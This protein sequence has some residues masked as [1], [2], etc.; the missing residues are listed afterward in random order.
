MIP[1]Y[2]SY[3]SANHFCN[4]LWQSDFHLSVES[5]LHGLCFEIL[6]ELIGWKRPTPRLTNQ[7]LN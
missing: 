2:Q 5:N 4:Y 3:D 1:V 6:R 7:K